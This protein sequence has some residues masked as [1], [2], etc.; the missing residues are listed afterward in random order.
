MEK[1]LIN[2]A[3]DRLTEIVGEKNV[4]VEKYP[5]STCGYIFYIKDIEFLC[6]LRGTITT[7]N[8]GSTQK[9][10]KELQQQSNK[11]I[12]IIA[13]TIYP[14]LMKE[15]IQNG[16]NSLDIA[17]NCQIKVE[18]L[19]V[20]IEGKRQALKDSIAITTKNRLFQETGLKI[21]FRLLNDPEWINL[22]YRQMQVSANVSLGSV[23]IIMNELIDSGY[24]LKT[25]KGKFLKNKKDLLER[26]IMGYNDLLK[27]KLFMNRMTFK[28]E[29]IKNNW[30]KL[31]LPT[32]TY[33]GGEPAANLYDGYL[34]PE[35]F[36]IYGGTTGALVKAGLRANEN[37][38]IFVYSK[39][40]SI[41]NEEKKIPTLLIY[42]DLMGS[43]NSRNIEAAHRIYDNEL[44][45]LK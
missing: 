37:G 35:Q 42:A 43:G 24:V 11:P 15:L 27:P 21:I 14:Q 39:F 19:F 23:N 31:P 12:L 34:Y 18:G 44:Q 6:E 5:N 7:S 4:R 45:H 8:F 13:Q 40:W 41:T 32:D 20:H 30:A 33:W 26:W 2:D 3:V 1:K 38:E 9:K 36:T 28:D 10:L 25:E 22:P 16:I 17:G 29:E